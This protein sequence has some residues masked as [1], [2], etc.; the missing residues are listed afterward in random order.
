MSSVPNIL[1]T[2]E[3]ESRDVTLVGSLLDTFPS[4]RNKNPTYIRA[5]RIQLDSRV[6]SL[7]VTANELDLDPES[8][9]YAK[10]KG[11]CDVDPK[12]LV[13]RPLTLSFSVLSRRHNYGRSLLGYYDDLDD[14]KVGER[15]EGLA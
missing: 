3:C 10:L 13:R 6:M 5:N 9:S 7:Q 14:S 8:A 15:S 1:F 2:G 4:S 12:M 11:R